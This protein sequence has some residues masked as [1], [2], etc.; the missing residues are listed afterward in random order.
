MACFDDNLAVE[1]LEGALPRDQT[2]QVE[3]HAA[4][5]DACRRLLAELARAHSDHG[6]DPEAMSPT[7]PAAGE[8]HRSLDR[9]QPVGRFIVL[10]RL[11]AGGMGVVFS[12]YDPKLDRKVALKLLHSSD[13]STHD[14]RQAQARLLREAQTIAQLAHPNVIA[15]YDVG[16][17]ESEVYIAMELVEGDTL[18][19]WLDKCERPLAD[20]VDKFAQAGR[21]LVAAHARGLLHRD[22]KPDNVLVGQDERVRV[23]D[24]GLAR[25]LFT[26]GTPGEVEAGP[27]RGG[28]GAW[29][30]PLTRTGMLLGTPR[31]MAPEQLA[32]RPVDAR[33]DQFSFCVALYE[34][35]YGCHPFERGMALDL[36]EGP[37]DSALLSPPPKHGVPDWVHRVIVRGL[38]ADPSQRYPSMNA[39]LQNLT[40]PPAVRRSWAPAL[41]GV[42]AA[43]VL[44]GAV[45]M[46]EPSG[47]DAAPALAP[48]PDPATEARLR[49]ALAT[50]GDLERDLSALGQELDQVRA[51][52]RMRI[53]ELLHQIEAREERI[54]DLLRETRQL[55]AELSVR[56][57]PGP[58]GAVGLAAADVDAVIERRRTDLGD[59]FRE[60]RERRPSDEGTMSVE[61]VVGPTGAVQ[62]A[63]THG[64]RD[65]ALELCVTGLLRA[66]IYPSSEAW[67]TALARLSL[68]DGQLE[69]QV[70][71]VEVT[72]DAPP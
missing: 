49:E 13:G 24:F 21:A 10:S 72:E 30:H 22:F 27:D 37:G 56:T 17:F 52:D 45:M 53:Q 57:A 44:T 1:F 31:Y 6:D 60:W 54:E 65:R 50:I 43:A 28:R 48:A 70:D 61:L 19:R 71:I 23:M 68:V 32:G 33:S 69:R 38:R 9:G 35:V 5:C 40:P 42:A 39:L 51:H 41:L 34:A 20:I 36:I 18:R 29:D 7:I 8:A 3:A 14:P 59:C 16:T 63:W 67:T 47:T 11:G 12:A 46:Q 64:I 58:R 15:V 66:P 26:D 2:R 25:S 55:R 4:R 62:V